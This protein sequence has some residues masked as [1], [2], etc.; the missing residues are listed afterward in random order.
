MH[1]RAQT[2][3]RRRTGGARQPWI[4]D[5]VGNIHQALHNI[6]MVQDDIAG[7]VAKALKD[8]IGTDQSMTANHEPLNP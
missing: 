8:S 2:V 4:C 5:L 6:L 7:A 3:A 1:I